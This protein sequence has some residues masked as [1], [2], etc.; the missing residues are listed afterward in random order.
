MVKSPAA[1]QVQEAGAEA[2]RSNIT[3][4][5]QPHAQPA[6]SLHG[7]RTFYNNDAI[8]VSGNSINVMSNPMTGANPH[9]FGTTNQR[10]QPRQSSVLT[11]GS[12]AE[13][14][15]LAQ[16]LSTFQM[17]AIITTKSAGN[18]KSKGGRNIKNIIKMASSR[19]GLAE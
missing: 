5:G 10:E 7:L 14:L 2:C 6:G 8:S 13:G 1:D 18:I 4:D 17:N 15:K 19:E 3:A 11:S 9:H 16:S 12:Q